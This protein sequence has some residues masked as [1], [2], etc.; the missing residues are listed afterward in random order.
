[1]PHAFPELR[2]EYARLWQTMTINADRART[3]KARA[4]F[5]LGNMRAYGRIAEKTG[6][7]ALV[8]AAIQERESSG[9]MRCV[10]HN[11]ERIIGTGRK[12]RLVPAGRGPFA[13]FEEAA[14]D[15]LAI[16]GLSKV[17]EWSLERALYQLERYNG[18]GPR[19]RGIH[20]GYLWAGTNHY[21]RGKYVA[22]GKWDPNHV[23]RQ[24]G[25]AALMRALIER[26]PSLSLLGAA[27][28]SGSALPIGSARDPE[29]KPSP[30][31]APVRS[32]G[33]PP[34]PE[35]TSNMDLVWQLLRYGLIA[36]GT[37]LVT[38]GFLTEEQMQAAVGA[39]VALGTVGWGVFVKSGTKAV[40]AHVAARP[41]VPT[42]S[43]AT[44]R[45]E[46]AS[47]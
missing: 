13:S 46:T 15:A 28:H 1:M 45:V 29:P 36:G 44:G 38:K 34:A 12:T 6:V 14:I 33:N 7:P 16:D 22:D 31:P 26:D 10:L 17:A 39:A 24:L 35:R 11:G 41:E 43:A 2:D 25:C 9:D 21:A 23:D 37:T 40:P 47:A 3:L 42:V 19:N 27:P 18:F 30:K 20:T 4:T 8:I 32:A 5:L